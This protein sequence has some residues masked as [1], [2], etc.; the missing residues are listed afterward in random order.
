MSYLIPQD[1]HPSFLYQLF[2]NI[3]SLLNPFPELVGLRSAQ[4]LLFRYS[5]WLGDEAHPMALV[6]DIFEC[7]Q[8]AKVEERRSLNDILHHSHL[9]DLANEKMS[10]KDTMQAVGYAEMLAHVQKEKPAQG[11]DI[12]VP[13]ELLNCM[14]A[15]AYKHAVATIKKAQNEVLRKRI[16]NYCIF[17]L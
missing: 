11:T 9:Q 16:E 8:Q 15:D 10:S 13:E 2:I 6:H 4:F 5:D 17:Y 7:G 12:F 1:V 3:A 14:D